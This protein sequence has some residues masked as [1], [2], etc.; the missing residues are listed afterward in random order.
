MFPA[1]SAAWLISNEKFMN[2][3]STIDYAKLRVSWGKSGNN[4][5]ANYG[6]GIDVG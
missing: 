2:S 3:Y 4:Q 6:A 1:L 5:I